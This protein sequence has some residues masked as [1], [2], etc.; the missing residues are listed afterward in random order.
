[1]LSRGRLVL[2][3]FLLTLFVLAQSEGDRG[4]KRAELKRVQR[5]IDSLNAAI[6]LATREEKKNYQLLETYNRQTFLLNEVLNGL[7]SEEEERRIR[8]EKAET[9]LAS[10]M[11][12][13]T[14]LREHYAA[15]IVNAYKRSFYDDAL[16]ILG[17]ESFYQ[18]A[19]R[20]KYLSEISRAGKQ[21]LN[22]LKEIKDE[23][24][25]TKT[26]VEQ[27]QNDK[28]ALLKEKE[29]EEQ[30]LAEM[31]QE[32]KQ[33]VEDIKR[34]ASSL[35]EE[36][37]VKKRAQGQI[38]NLIAS[39]D[40]KQEDKKEERRRLQ[41]ERE[42]KLLKK[43]KNEVKPEPTKEPVAEEK[44]P[45][46]PEKKPAPV[47]PKSAEEESL[48]KELEIERSLSSFPALKGSMKWPV[49]ATGVFRKF[50][51]TVNEKL[52]T[53]TVNY[54]IDIKTTT[55]APVRTVAEGVVSAIEW[56]PGFGSVV[57]INHSDS[58]RTVYGHLEALYVTV[59]KRLKSGELVGT[60]GETLE[61]TLLHFEIWQKRNY[62]NPESWLARR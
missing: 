37:E 15:Y 6:K 10:I 31:I 12:D 50:G 57:V 54:G 59:G 40:K 56:I 52:N 7:R 17:S 45:A 41:K 32:K 42:E 22:R 28:V 26:L 13:E 62:L 25:S 46:V 47:V 36:L 1:M 21:S 49:S 39:L 33:A 18:V 53:V 44:A 34:D 11:N 60:V 58:Y 30:R 2:I 35:K 14:T 3:I 24:S 5:E 51:E 29:G 55:S 16:L 23:I 19:H 43:K 61:G 48:D 27:E 4:D 38:K 20:L 8:I 9:Q